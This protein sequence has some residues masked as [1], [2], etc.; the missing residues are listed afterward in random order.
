M[1]RANSAQNNRRDFSSKPRIPL[2]SFRWGGAVTGLAKIA[3]G[4]QTWAVPPIWLGVVTGVVVVFGFTIFH[5]LVIAD[6][7]FNIGPMLIAGAVCGF[8]VAWSYRRAVVGHSTGAWFRY[9]GLYTVEMIVLGAVSV[10]VLQPRFTMAELLVADNDMELLMPQSVPLM[11]G[12]M[13]VGTVLFWLYYDRRKAAFFPILVTQVLL[14]FL[15]GHQLAFLGLVESSST[16]IV[17]FGEF[18]L[19][20]VGITV[21]FCFG[22]MGSTIALHRLRPK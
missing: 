2:G 7:W 3:R 16:L 10:A 12:T 15:L 5:N 6:I 4:V 11:V 8:C 18:A 9:A 21:T 22:V 19:I 13:V 1:A 20:V 17:A 14:V